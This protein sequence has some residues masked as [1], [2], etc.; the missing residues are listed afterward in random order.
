MKVMRVPLVFLTLALLWVRPAAAGEGAD[1]SM[2]GEVTIH[3]EWKP[4]LFMMFQRK[5]KCRM[6]L[7]DTADAKLVVFDCERTRKTAT[8]KIHSVE[9]S[10][11][12]MLWGPKLPLARH[13]LLM[14]VTKD[15]TKTLELTTPKGE[16][17][18]SY[19]VSADVTTLT[20][21]KRRLTTCEGNYFTL[22]AWKKLQQYMRDEDAKPSSSGSSE[23]DGNDAEDVR[24]PS[25]SSAPA[26]SRSKPKGLE[27][28]R[29][30]GKDSECQSGSCKMEN[31]TRGRCS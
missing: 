27:H 31:R 9:G 25:S 15:T 24:S 8:C 26:P 22:D 23:D 20:Q 6:D 11:L 2:D 3:G 18:I 21:T 19:D 1:S 12:A 16:V 17:T 4:T 13:A 30:C 7:P 10:Q 29:M 5:G 28:G 14:S